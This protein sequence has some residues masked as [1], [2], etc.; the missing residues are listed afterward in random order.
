MLKQIEAKILKVL[1]E[2]EEN[3]LE[4]QT[5]IKVLSSSKNLSNEIEAKQAV[6]EVTEK[7]IDQARSQYKPIAENSTV[8][9]FTIGKN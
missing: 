8:L 1:S 6:A 5:A 2:S 4:D 7:N 3:I 9:F